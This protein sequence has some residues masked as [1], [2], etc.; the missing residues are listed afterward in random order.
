MSTNK[1]AVELLDNLLTQLFEAAI[2]SQGTSNISEKLRQ[3]REEQRRQSGADAHAGCTNCPTKKYPSSPMRLVQ[4]VASCDE[5]KQYRYDV[6]VQEDVI[7]YIDEA[8]HAAKAIVESCEHIVD[9]SDIMD[10]DDGGLP[11]L[12]PGV[13]SQTKP[14]ELHLQI[15][16]SEGVHCFNAAAGLMLE[17][18][19]DVK[20]LLGHR[21]MIKGIFNAVATV[22]EDGTVHLAKATRI[23]H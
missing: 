11:V 21:R 19:P 3:L 4:I 2:D 22:A 5:Q 1:K 23:V 10:K 13:A 20:R 8:T 15:D 14:G 7:V 9:L 17:L 16:G 18:L 12:L 6:I